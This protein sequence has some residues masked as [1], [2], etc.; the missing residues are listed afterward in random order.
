MTMAPGTP[1]AE[2]P[3]ISRKPAQASKVDG[4]PSGPSETRVAGCA[5]TS[6]MARSPIRPRKKPIPA[7]MPSLSESGMP[8]T[9]HSRT[10]SSE[11]RRNSSP[12]RNTAP[13]AA[14][15]DTPAPSTTAKVK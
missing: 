4:S 14:C 5:A 6:P 3:A 8:F 12:E 10:R 2:S 15:H 1:R 7:A 13:S 11:T 9:S